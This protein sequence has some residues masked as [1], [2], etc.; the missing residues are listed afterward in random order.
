M[1]TAAGGML[2]ISSALQES[3]PEVPEALASAVRRSCSDQADQ[4]AAAG[5][6]KSCTRVAAMRQE[7]DSPP[8]AAQPRLGASVY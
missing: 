1:C 8:G 7:E 5:M 2:R 6:P 3:V 4:E